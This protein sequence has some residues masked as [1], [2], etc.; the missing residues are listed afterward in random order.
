MVSSS[1]SAVYP[2]GLRLGRVDRIDVIPGAV[3]YKI[4]VVLA[5]DY[6]QLDHVQVIRPALQG[7]REKLLPQ[8][9]N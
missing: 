1:Y 4:R 2:P 8:A 7:E 9:L 3:T 5:T 6:R